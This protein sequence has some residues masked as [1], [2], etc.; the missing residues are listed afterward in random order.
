M[1]RRRKRY[2][3]L[4]VTLPSTSRI[5]RCHTGCR[6]NGFPTG[7]N[8]RSA[9]HEVVSRGT[10]ERPRF[11]SREGT[12]AIH[13]PSRFAPMQVGVRVRT[14]LHWRRRF[15]APY[16]ITRGKRGADT[17]LP[18]SPTMKT[19]ISGA[20][21]FVAI[22]FLSEFACTYICIYVDPLPR[23]HLRYGFE[24]LEYLIDWSQYLVEWS[25]HL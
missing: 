19:P 8:D 6:I 24:A 9:P 5:A 13:H 17:D 12:V 1:G 11:D 20:I 16:C 2:E 4:N 7:C 22:A 21:R 18:K 10:R 3:S 14:N 25:E 23:G 15:K